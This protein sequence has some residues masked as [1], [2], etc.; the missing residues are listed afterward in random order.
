[1]E[2]MITESSMDS[3]YPN[4]SKSGSIVAMLAGLWFMASPWVYGSFHMEE[5]WNNRIVG[6][7][8]TI[9]AIVRLSTDERKTRWIS[10]VNCLL[11]IWVVIS[12]WVFQYSGNT[13]RVINSLCVGVILFVGAMISA[14]SA[15][16][17][18]KPKMT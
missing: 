4:R 11:A 3:G 6:L 15:H 2:P 8:I 10:G 17:G 18:P 16:K 1:M 7:L 14:V 12:P 9:L 13:D 5:A